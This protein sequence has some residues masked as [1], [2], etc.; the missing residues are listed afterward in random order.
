MLNLVHVLCYWKSW[1]YPA[2]N[3]D[4]KRYLELYLEV[5]RAFFKENLSQRMSF[6]IVVRGE[7]SEES[8]INLLVV[9]GLEEDIGK[10]LKLSS[11]LKELHKGEVGI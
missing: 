3:E 5:L 11:G 7:A 8:N 2:L 4:L 1:I 10:K 9:E 6:G